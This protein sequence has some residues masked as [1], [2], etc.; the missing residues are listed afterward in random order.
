MKKQ[1]ACYNKDYPRPQMVRDSWRSLNGEWEFRFDDDGQGARHRWYENF[2]SEMKI[3]VPFSYETRLSG[4][5]TEKEHFCIWY[6]RNLEFSKSELVRKRVLL[7]FEGCDYLTSV[8]ING[9]K[10]GDHKGGYTRFSFDI[11]DYLTEEN[12]IVVRVEDSFDEQQLRGKQRW[13]TESFRCWYVQTTGIWKSVWMETVD[14]VHIS[15]LK[16]TPDIK[17][18]A[19]KIDLDVETGASEE[20]KNIRAEV[21]IAFREKL[22]NTIAFPIGRYHTTVQIDVTDIDEDTELNGIHLWSPDQPN[23]Y[24]FKILLYHGTRLCDEVGSYFGMREITTYHGNVLLNEEPIYQ[25]LILDQGYWSDSGLT[26]HSEEAIIEDIT[27][28]KE[29]GFNG[30]RKHQKIEDERYYYWCDVLGLLVW[31]EIPSAYRF[32]DRTVHNCMREISEIVEQHYNH[33][34]VI[35]WTVFNESWGVNEIRTDRQQQHFTEAAYHMIKSLDKLR[36]VVSNDGWEHTVSDIITLHDYEEDTEVFL[37]RYDG[38]PEKILEGGIYHNLIKSAFAE[39]YH[40]SGQPIM[41]SEYGGIAFRNEQTGW[42]YGN[43]VQTADEFITRYENITSA[44]K[45][46]PYLCGYCYTQLTDV[47]QEINGLM[48]AERNFKVAPEIIRSI[49]LKRLG[50]RMKGSEATE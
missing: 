9:K 38:N 5:K 32:G 2:Q 45:K 41:I 19:L 30:A 35:V 18:R 10:V 8:W 25:R 39:N 44:I 27:K 3:Q 7:H 17:E 22:I 33:P 26:P 42:G 28:T 36:L 40:Y 47:Y 20:Y 1:T 12:R 29:L 13:R 50:S 43:K 21:Q 31:C 24:D 23:L 46:L 49:N 48:D 11:T 14:E 37:E 34:S 4:I 6:A 16:L 15:S